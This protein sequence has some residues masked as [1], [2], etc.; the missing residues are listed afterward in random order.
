M[1]KDC[2]IQNITQLYAVENRYQLLQGE[3]NERLIYIHNV[4][5]PVIQ[6]Q[7]HIFFE[8]LPRIGEAT[9]VAGGDFNN[10]IDNYMDNQA[11]TPQSQS[12]FLAFQ[13]WRD[14]LHLLDAWRFVHPDEF[15]FTH[16]RRRIDMILVSEI[17]LDQIQQAKHLNYF[18][19]GD[20]KPVAAVFSK[21]WIQRKQAIWR[22]RPDLVY[23]PLIQKYIQKHLQDFIQT[24]PTDNLEIVKKYEEMKQNLKSNIKTLQFKIMSRDANTLKKLRQDVNQAKLIQAQLPSRFNANLLIEAEKQLVEFIKHSANERAQKGLNRSMDYGEKCSKLFLRQLGSNLTNKP[25]SAVKTS[26]GQVS[27]DPVQIRNVH[28]EFWSNIFQGGVEDDPNSTIDIEAQNSLIDGIHQRLTQSESESFESAFSDEEI[29]RVIK[30]LPDDSAPGLD[31]LSGAVYKVAIKEWTHVLQIIFKINEELQ[32]FTPSQRRSVISLLYKKL[33]PLYS[34]NYRPIS[35]LTVDS[36]IYT[37]ILSNRLKQVINHIIPDVQTGFMPSRSIHQNLLRLH[38]LI[39][40]CITNEVDGALVFLDFKKAYDMVNHNYLIRVLT[41]LGFGSHFINQIKTI[42]RRRTFSL[43]INGTLSSPC[44]IKRGVFQGDPLSCF[45]FAISLLPLLNLLNSHRHLGIKLQPEWPNEIGSFFADDSTL[46]AGSLQNAHT[47]YDLVHNKFCKG[48]GAVLHPGKTILMPLSKNPIPYSGPLN[49]LLPSEVTR[50]LGIPMGINAIMENQSSRFDT[51]IEKIVNRLKRWSFRGRTLKGRVTIIRSIIQSVLLYKVSIIPIGGKTIA[52]LHKTFLRFIKKTMNTEEPLSTSRKRG[53]FNEKWIHVPI[54]N[55]GLGYYPL[56]ETI[57]LLRIK[58]IIQLLTHVNLEEQE[59]PPTHLKPIISLMKQSQIWG[60]SP[61]DLFFMKQTGRKNQTNS[62]FWKY[63][64]KWW[65]ENFKLIA[66]D[67]KFH[68]NQSAHQPIWDNRFILYKE[69]PIIQSFP[70]HLHEAIRYLNKAQLTHVHDFIEYNHHDQQV[71][72]KTPQI[73]F[74][75]AFFKLIQRNLSALFLREIN[76]GIAVLRIHQ[77]LTIIWDDLPK[78]L[79]P[80]VWKV[81]LPGGEVKI[82]HNIE[83]QHFRSLLFIPEIPQTNYQAIGY[84]PEMV[85]TDNTWALQTKSSR[86]LLPM[87]NDLIWRILHNGL[88]VGHKLQY[89]WDINPKC[90]I[91]CSS[92]ETTQHLFW[93]CPLAQHLWDYYLGMWRPFW[94]EDIQWHHVLDP[95]T[96]TLRAY[97]KPRISRAA[98][99]IFCILR[100]IVMHYIWFNR[101]AIVF[102]EPERTLDVLCLRKRINKSFQRHWVSFLRLAPL[103]GKNHARRLYKILTDSSPMFNTIMDPN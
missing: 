25:I 92:I 11:I 18:P 96:L 69:K 54:K 74:E 3:L 23:H 40:K 8:N 73:L 57:K 58:H 7:Q 13:K 103:N 41:K 64:P 67:C 85:H 26:E 98:P 60:K 101:N 33:S 53:S 39:H 31:S 71:Q 87:E 77:L 90:S 62:L 68:P 47:L 36:K 49:M 17:L 14:D 84:P 83:K 27:T 52:N 44:D 59:Q 10:V 72:L 50:V 2:P 6:Q 97:F 75:Q 15:Q 93:N 81:K 1:T 9:H 76:L 30:Q 55:G 19:H 66:N 56:K 70:P 29:E 99:L 4:Y 35:L 38:D 65:I 63:I 12:S 86:Y 16:V 82:L 46:I 51:E 61:Q 89:A 100:A 22:P 43:N 94:E 42:Y 20:H 80:I 78:L 28:M 48:S 79:H 34:E 91:G 45:L 88:N 5:A 21:N 102:N 24:I 32:E 37:K 95:S